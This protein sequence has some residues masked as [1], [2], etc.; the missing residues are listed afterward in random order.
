MDVTST[1]AG[2]LRR[3]A[4]MTIHGLHHSYNNDSGVATFFRVAAKIKDG[5]RYISR[6][7]YHEGQYRVK[8]SQDMVEFGPGDFAEVVCRLLVQHSPAEWKNETVSLLVGPVQA[9]MLFATGLIRPV[10]LETTVDSLEF[11]GIRNIELGDFTVRVRVEETAR[12]IAVINTQSGKAVAT[13]Q[14]HGIP[15]PLTIAL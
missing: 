14:G 11:L 15:C 8:D 12:K 2:S 1:E 6:V 3:K 10:H 13:P 4:K 9:A 7:V 5:K